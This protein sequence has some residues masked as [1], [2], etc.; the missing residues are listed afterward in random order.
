MLKLLFFILL[1]VDLTLCQN[2]LLGGCG[3]PLTNII[4]PYFPLFGQNATN[5][6]TQASLINI[7]YEFLK[8]DGVWCGYSMTID[9]LNTSVVVTSVVCSSSSY[10]GISIN[11]TNGCGITYS[12]VLNTSG[13]LINSMPPVMPLNLCPKIN[14]TT[15]GIFFIQYR[16]NNPPVTVTVS[17]TY[18]SDIGNLLASDGVPESGIASPLFVDCLRNLYYSTSFA[19][20]IRSRL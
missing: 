7:P 4:Y 5:Y 20:I 11:N 9:S 13:P 15:G 6:Y 12:S 14:S 2:I 3:L 18:P 19:G 16:S 1:C 8:E 10:D 17:R